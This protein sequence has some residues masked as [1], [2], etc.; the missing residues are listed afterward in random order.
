MDIARLRT[1]RELSLRHT[2]A[3]V[4]EALRISPSAVSQQIGL[5]EAEAGLPLIERRGRRVRL[6][7]AGQRLVLH[8]ERVIAVL[9]AAKTE[10]AELKQ[11]VTGELR[12]AAFS[13]VAAALI[14]QTMKA[15][16]PWCWRRWS[17][18]TRLPHCAR[19]RRMS[20]WSTI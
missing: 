13:S 12:V 19:G 9:E 11:A 18:W 2:M 8:A 14:P 3:A 10:L 17:R 16:E 5:L 6:T 1:L 4:A 7:Q 15:L 20:R